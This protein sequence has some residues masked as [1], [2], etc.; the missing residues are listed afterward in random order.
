[1]TPEARSTAVFKRGTWKGF[2]GSTPTG[3]QQLPNS[4]VGA[5]LL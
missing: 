3:G 4:G 2:K 1:M 5:R